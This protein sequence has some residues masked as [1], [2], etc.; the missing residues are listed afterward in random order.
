MKCL[1]NRDTQ[2]YSH[3]CAVGMHLCYQDGC[4]QVTSHIPRQHV[5]NGAHQPPRCASAFHCQQ[6]H[7]RKLQWGIQHSQ[8]L[9]WYWKWVATAPQLQQQS[10]R[11]AP[12]TMSTVEHTPWRCRPAMRM[13]LPIWATSSQSPA[14][15][16]SLCCKVIGF[17]TRFRCFLPLC[18]HM[19]LSRGTV[20]CMLSHVQHGGGI[21]SAACCDVQ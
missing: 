3:D 18:L 2:Q 12:S 9:C 14:Q 1:P 20:A 4:I 11:S 16:A 5:L 15:C 8:D 13:A 19:S 6:V 7:C 21:L 17:F 10:W